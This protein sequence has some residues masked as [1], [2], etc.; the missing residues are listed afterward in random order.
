LPAGAQA[1]VSLKR[2]GT[3]AQ[4]RTYGVDSRGHFLIEGVAAGS[5]ELN[6]NTYF[7]GRRVTGAKQLLNI[8][9]GNV[10]DVVVVLELKGNPDPNP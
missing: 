10:S 3:E 8:T 5:Y 6:V 1:S 9:E 7:P 4:L 2:S